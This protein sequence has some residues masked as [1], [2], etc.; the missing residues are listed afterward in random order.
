MGSR[1]RVHASC[2]SKSG[3]GVLIVG[4]P[5]SGKSD[6]VVRLLARGFSLVADDQVDVVDGRASPPPALA[7]LLEVRGLG[8]LKV[9]PVFPVLLCLVVELGPPTDRLPAPEFDPRLSLPRIRIDPT[10]PSAP[11]RVS[12]AL[13]CAAGRITQHAGVFAG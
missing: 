9:V 4:P 11:E 5:G 1:W 2:A 13:E 3:E 7:G 10:S 6:L 12:L 8:I